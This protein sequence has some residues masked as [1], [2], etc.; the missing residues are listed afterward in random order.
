MK[1]TKWLKILWMKCNY[2][3]IRECWKIV[4]HVTLIFLFP[5][6]LP[7]SPPSFWVL[8]LEIQ[9]VRRWKQGL[10]E[11]GH[12]KGSSVSWVQ[13][14][15]GKTGRESVLHSCLLVLSRPPSFSLVLSF[16]RASYQMV[17]TAYFSKAEWT[18]NPSSRAWRGRKQELHQHVEARTREHRWE[19]GSGSPR[20]SILREKYAVMA[21]CEDSSLKWHCSNVDLLQLTVSHPGLSPSLFF[22]GMNFIPILCWISYFLHSMSIT[23]PLLEQVL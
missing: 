13:D 18:A 4:F 11:M 5:L 22:W 6:S 15:C 3:K 14:V 16:H 9:W 7:P 19:P 12:L 1:N 23:F 20:L 21:L 10:P 17:E 2:L 8:Q